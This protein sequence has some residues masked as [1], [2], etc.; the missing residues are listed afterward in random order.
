[1]GRLRSAPRRALGSLLPWPGRQVDAPAACRGRR[2]VHVRR[3]CVFLSSRHCYSV[4]IDPMHKWLVVVAVVLVSEAGFAQPAFI[5]LSPSDSFPLG[6]SGDGSTV[7]GRAGSNAVRWVDGAP[8][9]AIAA[10]PGASSVGMSF[11]VSMDG[12]V[13]VGFVE[14]SQGQEAFRWTASAG[15]ISIG[16]LHGATSDAV[17]TGV[18]TDGLMV[19]GFDCSGQSG[20]PCEAFSWTNS[21]GIV[22]QGHLSGG[23]TY[24]T[25]AA[26]SADGSV[27]VGQSDSSLGQEAVRWTPSSGMEGLG[28]LGGAHDVSADGTTIVGHDSESLGAFVWME[29]GSFQIPKSLGDGNYSA[30]GVSANGAKVVGRAIVNDTPS[31]AFLWSEE[32]GTQDLL[33][34]LTEMGLGS[35]LL[36]WSL[37]SAQSISFNGTVIAGQGV[38]PSGMNQ[39]FVVEIPD[40]SPRE[41]ITIGELPRSTATLA[42]YQNNS[43]EDWADVSQPGSD[44]RYG[45]LSR[46]DLT[47]SNLSAANLS[48]ADLSGADLS[49]SFLVGT[50]LEGAIVTS[51]ILAGAYYNQ[52]TLF[53]SGGS[54][55]EPPWGL[56]GNVEPWNAGMIPLP[57]PTAG[58]L[59]GIG[60]LALGGGRRS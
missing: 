28:I 48:N 6:I 36:G 24:S 1:M 8:A 60:V 4:R 32:H 18:T 45:V 50:N 38:N 49:S 53:P 41:C 42:A 52:T 13:V 40:L 7:V 15:S 54:W 30:N 39:A 43:C 23:G 16:H 31:R 51:T 22:G 11:D 5:P 37:S 33:E 55:N 47:L 12:S 44:L 57:E 3:F 27:A 34:L 2:V 46:A 58:L 19:V 20:R 10:P 56:D 14:G 29:S 9:V 59:L 35:Q 26:V 17:A 25:F 21:T